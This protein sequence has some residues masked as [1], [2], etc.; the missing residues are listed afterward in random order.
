MWNRKDLKKK[1]KDLLKKNYW[2]FV[3]VCFIL[4]ICTSDFKI[5]SMSFERNFE[6]TNIIKSTDEIF[7]VKRTDSLLKDLYSTGI[8]PDNI[9][10]LI[11][12]NNLFKQFE[13][14]IQ[15]NIN[16]TLKSQKYVYKIVDASRL[17]SEDFTLA[18]VLLLIAAAIAFLFII[19]VAEPLSVGGKRF[20]IKSTEKSNQ[21]LSLLISVFKVD[22]WSN[23]TKIM[24]LKN[25]YCFLW[26]FTIIGGFIKHYEYEMIPYILADNPNIKEK[27]AFKLSSQLMKGNK[28]RSFILDISFFLWYIL[29]ILTLGLAAVLYVNSYTF[30]TKTEMYLTLKEEAIKHKKDYY[31]FLVKTKTTEIKKA[32]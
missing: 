3:I 10:K 27:D 29:S 16:S 11:S 1:A 6:S 18:G 14:Y 21:K 22:Q 9:V 26:F 24:L 7:N 25:L 13:T 2:S 15:S 23:I 19:L 32:I 12:E 28:F 17:L 31:N 4:S 5:S 30:A 20:F 8:I